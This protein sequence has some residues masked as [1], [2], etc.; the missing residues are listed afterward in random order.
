M[1]GRPCDHFARVEISDSLSHLVAAGLVLS[2][3][4]P[5]VRVVDGCLDLLD[6]GFRAGLR[7]STKVCVC[8]AFHR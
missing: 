5:H 4:V 8:N 6:D 2:R 1:V 7:R 3:H